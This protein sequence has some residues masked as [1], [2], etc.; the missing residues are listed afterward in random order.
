VGDTQI[1]SVHV[2]IKTR[3]FSNQQGRQISNLFSVDP[4]E[5]LVKTISG[6]GLTS[7][8]VQQAGMT[9]TLSKDGAFTVFVPTNE[10]LEEALQ[11]DNAIR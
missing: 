5:H 4:L 1:E 3:L 7:F 11:L 6:L 8:P 10:A 9:R 2:V